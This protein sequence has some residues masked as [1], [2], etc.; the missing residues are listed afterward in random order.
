M[1]SL[2][3]EDS[4]SFFNRTDFNFARGEERLVEQNRIELWTFQKESMRSDVVQGFMFIMVRNKLPEGKLF[5]RIENNADSNLIDREDDQI[6]TKEEIFKEARERLQENYAH[7][8]KKKSGKEGVEKDQ[9]LISIVSKMSHKYLDQLAYK[10][11]SGPFGILSNK[12]VSVALANSPSQ[13]ISKNRANKLSLVG[14]SSIPQIELNNKFRSKKSVPLL[15]SEHEVFK[16]EKSVNKA[17]MLV[18]KFTVK[19]ETFTLVSCDQ[20]LYQDLD[21]VSNLPQGN[22]LQSQFITNENVASPPVGPNLS[23]NQHHV[24]RRSIMSEQ[25]NAQIL[26]QTDTRTARG[27]E[28]IS[29]NTKI[30]AFYVTNSTHAEFCNEPAETRLEK[31]RTG[32]NFCESS[33]DLEVLERLNYLDFHQWRD[34]AEIFLSR[35]GGTVSPKEEIVI[36]PQPGVSVTVSHTH[37]QE[38]IEISKAPVLPHVDRRRSAS[39]LFSPSRIY[40]NADSVGGANNPASASK[41]IQG[42]KMQMI[43]GEPAPDSLTKSGHRA[44][45]SGILKLQLSPSTIISPNLAKPQKVESLLA[46][47]VS[48][49][50]KSSLD[51]A[52]T[53]SRSSNVSCWEKFK[54]SINKVVEYCS[55]PAPLEL[56]IQILLDKRVYSRFDSTLSVVLQYHPLL[57]TRYTTLDVVIWKKRSVREFVPHR[58][59]VY[60]LTDLSN[61]STM[62]SSVD[63]PR[64]H[65]YE[66]VF[67]E[68]VP[69]VRTDPVFVKTAEGPKSAQQPSRVNRIEYRSAKVDMVHQFS[70]LHLTKA[71]SSINTTY[72]SL[73]FEIEFFLSPGPGQ[74]ELK[75]FTTDLMFISIPDDFVRLTKEQVSAYYQRFENEVNKKRM[76]HK[77]RDKEYKDLVIWLPYAQIVSKEEFEKEQREAAQFEEDD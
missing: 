40:E 49:F 65:L 20:I 38:P 14:L 36:V 48:N 27:L 6:P 17:A 19:L 43:E 74:L 32:E 44:S 59:Q 39:A 71:Y 26:D 66:I 16:I 73:S 75:I 28:F 10:P 64:K 58:N 11:D 46:S 77:E 12:N 76:E 50:T 62:N 29:I 68:T 24:S 37:F 30:T 2:D 25:P 18:C 60:G 41:T 15:V 1:A 67:H 23:H 7:N 72:F 4:N 13:P 21:E 9:Q 55:K 57:A 8:S 3:E 69:I 35:Y 53:A 22:L 45:V 31:Y 34:Q 54:D 61:G 51:K 52:N 42:S 63:A 47:S 70:I 56:P 33:T 5:L